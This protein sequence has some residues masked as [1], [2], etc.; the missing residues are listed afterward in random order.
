MLYSGPPR[1]GRKNTLMNPAFFPSRNTYAIE[2]S[3]MGM[4]NDVATS[5]PTMPRPGML[6]RTQRKA[7]GTAI[8]TDGGIVSTAAS[9][10]FWIGR[11][12][13]LVKRARMASSSMV[14]TLMTTG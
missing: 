14:L 4:T 3:N 7:I 12:W 9:N 10:E 2:V 6:V 13:S 5:T 1:I 8:A 11:I